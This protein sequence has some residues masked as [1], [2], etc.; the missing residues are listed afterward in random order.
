VKINTHIN[1]FFFVAGVKGST[2]FNMLLNKVRLKGI[3]DDDDVCVV[4]VC[5]CVC[6][7]V[8]SIQHALQ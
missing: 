1:F 6:V 3:D 2:V 5:V 8:F 4:C 7:C